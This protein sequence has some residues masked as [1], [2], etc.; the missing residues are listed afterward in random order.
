VLIALML[1]E[2]ITKYWG[3]LGAGGAEN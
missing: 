3:C 1:G 2:V